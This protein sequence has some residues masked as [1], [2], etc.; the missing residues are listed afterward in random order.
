MK[1][2]AILVSFFLPMLS[3]CTLFSPVSVDTQKAV[4][5][6]IP[7]RLP[8]GNAR[9]ATLLILAPTSS[10]VYDTTQMAYAIQPY[11]VAYFSQNEWIETPSR[12]IHPLL[13]RTLEGTHSFSAVLTP[14]YMGR[15]TYALQTQILELKQDFT[16]Q[17][18]TLLLAL[19]FQ[20]T[21]GAANEVIAS[22]EVTLR[23][24]MRERTPYAGAVAANDAMANA[25]Q[26]LAEFVLANAG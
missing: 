23:E 13:V 5:S 15:F 6:Q 14:P 24:S 11:Q 20:L 10:A 2:A 3:S 8:H 25:L 1:R 7:T 17:P 21:R 4:L 16:S 9:S 26:Q 22:K 18:P 12:M 19:R